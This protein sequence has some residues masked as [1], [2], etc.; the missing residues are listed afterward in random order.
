M[1]LAS[2][3]P[4]AHAPGPVLNLARLRDFVSAFAALLDEAPREELILKH[5]GQLLAQ[6]V[7]HDDWLP[8]EYAAPSPLRY[9]QYLLHCDSRE[10]FS[11]V[12]FV[13]GPGQQ[14]PVH[15]H[16]VWGLIGMLRGAEVSH[17]FRRTVDG[18]LIEST[19]VERLTPGSIS[20]VSPTVGDIHK[21]ENA[22]ANSTS[23]S[24]HVYGANIGRVERSTYDSE[25]L[26]KRFVS[27][28]AN[29]SV[30]N[31]WSQA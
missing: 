25:G 28:Y 10:R 5:G 21:V 17:S 1:T 22:F 19:S 24:I 30:P 20:A 14:T 27:G 12:S 11:V 9:Q 18:K 2:A 23:I 16:T 29:R 8:E 26:P 15:D 4:E 6:L 31:I 3:A 13:W 7:K